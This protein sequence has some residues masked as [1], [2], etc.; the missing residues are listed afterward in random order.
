MD[1]NKNEKNK[2]NIGQQILPGLRR[3]C[4]FI[5]YLNSEEKSK[6]L[7]ETYMYELISN[8]N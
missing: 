6:P 5:Y 8:L 7:K 2:L 4:R 3:T 1:Y